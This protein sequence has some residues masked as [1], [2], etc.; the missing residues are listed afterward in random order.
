MKQY[1]VVDIIDCFGLFLDDVVEAESK[2]D[3]LEIVLNE[4]LDNIGNYIDIVLEE[5]EVVESEEQ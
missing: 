3:A 4:I 5:V 2:S 1:R